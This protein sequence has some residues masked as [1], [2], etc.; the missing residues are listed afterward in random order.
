MPS[1]ECGFNIVP[2]ATNADELLTLYG[3]TLAV[4]IGFDP[5]FKPGAGL[6]IPVPGI[7]GV[8]ALVDTGASESCIDN[9]LAATLNLPIVDRRQIAGVG[10]AH[11][12][13]VYLAQVRVPG[14]NVTI[15]GAFAGVQLAAGG[16]HHQ[17][18][19]GRTFLT[20]LKMTYDGP[21]GAVTI[22]T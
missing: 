15:Y 3:P 16:Q 7:T 22:S 1:V 14:L 18:L 5:S 17:A 10:G 9:L 11:E 6:P 21:T 19:M 8:A 12:V 2:G 4:D 20:G 13:N